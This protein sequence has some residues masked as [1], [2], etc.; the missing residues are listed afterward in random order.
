MDRRHPRRGRA[1]AAETQDRKAGRAIELFQLAFLE[2]AAVE[3]PLADFALKGGGNLRFF[4]RSRRRSRDLELD[5]LGERFDRFAERVDRVFASRALAE[6]LR[7]RDLAP[8][9]PRRSKDTATVKRWNLSL[10]APGMEVASSKIEFSG[11][12]ATAYVA[13]DQI[14]ESLARRLRGRA[15][16][17]NH[18][19]AQAAIEQKVHAL[20]QRSETQPRDVFDLDHLIREY[21]DAMRQARIDAGAARAAMAR[22]LELSYEHYAQLVV[23]YLEEE[24]VPLYGSEESWNDMV[25]RVTAELEGRLRERRG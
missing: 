20:A 5:H 7:A 24:F 13:F 2:V 19:P 23:E 1:V 22:A 6:L 17:L 8:V 15:V 12:G 11:R 21:P 4:L 16:R 10:A 18:Y 25:L 14:D 9:D 3:L